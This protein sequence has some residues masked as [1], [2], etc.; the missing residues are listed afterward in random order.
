MRPHSKCH[1]A[2]PSATFGYFISLNLD[3]V[4]CL[5]FLYSADES[6]EHGAGYAI[7]VL[8]MEGQGEGK[9]L[10]FT[11]LEPKVAG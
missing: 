7:P 4:A 3:G 1:A 6:F 11:P 10:S 2:A 9:G 5:S 8:S